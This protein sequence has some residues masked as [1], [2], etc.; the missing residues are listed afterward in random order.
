MCQP[1]NRSQGLEI[2]HFTSFGGHRHRPIVLALVLTHVV[3][4]MADEGMLPD[5]A[6]IWS[7][8]Y[9][10]APLVFVRALGRGGPSG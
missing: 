1:D 10:L 9:G 8:V 7:V 6:E 2:A 4:L 5:Q 3:D